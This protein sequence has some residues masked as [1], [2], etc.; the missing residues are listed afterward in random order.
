MEPEAESVSRKAERTAEGTDL[1]ENILEL[2]LSAVVVGGEQLAARILG[3]DILRQLCRQGG[4]EGGENLEGR[5]LTF[6]GGVGETICE[7]RATFAS[8]R[9]SFSIESAWEEGGV[10][11]AQPGQP[12]DA[13]SRA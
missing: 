1:Q 13:T 10:R 7:R 12:W 9:S 8:K 2:L 3:G 6:C 11:S 4:N 5:A